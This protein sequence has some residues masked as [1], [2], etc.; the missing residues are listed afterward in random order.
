[1]KSKNYDR[2]KYH[3]LQD[4]SKVAGQHQIGSMVHSMHSRKGASLEGEIKGSKIERGNIALGKKDKGMI[5]EIFVVVDRVA[6]GKK[7]AQR[8]KG[9]KEDEIA[10]NYLILYLVPIN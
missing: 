4:V 6:D 8:E 2:H 7:E 1:M 10:I 3:H 5:L 9:R